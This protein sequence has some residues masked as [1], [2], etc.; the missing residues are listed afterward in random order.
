MTEE[1]ENASDIVVQTEGMQT[2]EIIEEPVHAE[3]TFAEIENGRT[4]KLQLSD[5]VIKLRYIPRQT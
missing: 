1:K 4:M 5:Q 2:A 3:V